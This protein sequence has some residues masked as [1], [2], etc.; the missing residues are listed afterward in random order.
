MCSTCYVPSFLQ[1]FKKISKTVFELQKEHMYLTWVT[2]DNVQRAVTSKAGNSVLRLEFC[3][4]F[5]GD[6]HLHQVSRKD[7]EKFLSYR[8][9]TNLL[10]KSLFSKFNGP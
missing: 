9:D 6:I 1:G 10:Q 8:V 3:K 7:L 2:S 5:H 4:L